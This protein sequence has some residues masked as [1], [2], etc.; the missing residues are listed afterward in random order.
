MRRWS[1][2]AEDLNWRSAATIEDGTPIAPFKIGIGSVSRQICKRRTEYG[3]TMNTSIQTTV[4]ELIAAL[5]DETQHL[6]WLK[7]REKQ[8]LV[9]FI[10]NDL[11]QSRSATRTVAP[12]R[13]DRGG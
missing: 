8:L 1:F 11:V 12:Q 9:A 6:N 10:V 13:R 7:A 3:S 2:N 4:G 5:F